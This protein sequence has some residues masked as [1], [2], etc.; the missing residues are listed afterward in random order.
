MTGPLDELEL[1]GRASTHIVYLHE[2][3]ARLQRDVVEPFLALR[4]AA[5]GDGF[6]LAAASSFRDF[7]QQARIW[8]EKFE[9]R[10]PLHDRRGNLLDASSLDDGQIV[11]AILAWSA[12][13]GASRHH[14][15][16]DI[17]VFD[18]A[19]LTTDH[20]RELRP[21][22]FAP[23]GV[24]GGMTVWLDANLHRFG[25]FRPYDRDRGGVMVEPWHISHAA[26]AASALAALTV[27]IVA[28][29]LR[30]TDLR[31][32]HEAMARLPEIFERYVVNVGCRG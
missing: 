10:R 8:N 9:G 14:W 31:G 18:R 22:L 24:F 2:L 3:R 11:D 23:G 5:A 7:A 25:F 26:T 20:P 32:G 1:T 15:G 27:G 29:A 12:L 19:A 28:D 21:E 17:D 13:P 4:R 6:D 30:H 16:T